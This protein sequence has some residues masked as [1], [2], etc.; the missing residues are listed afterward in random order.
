VAITPAQEAIALL[1][2]LA[3]RGEINPW[4]VQ[5]IEIIDRFLS[6]LGL[7]EDHQ[8]LD[9]KTNL[10]QSGQAFVWASM[11][12][13]LK[14]KTLENLEVQAEEIEEIEPEIDDHSQRALP[15][16]LE[17]HIRRRPAA[18]PPR[19]RRVTLQELIEQIEQ[20]AAELGEKPIKPRKVKP[21]G[22]SRR[23]T[24]RL[25]AELAHNENLTEIAGHLERFFHVGL[26]LLN[27]QQSEIELDQLLDWWSEMT[28]FPES[29]HS[30]HKDCN[31]AKKH[32]R[33]GVF[34]ALLLLSSQSKVE[35]CQKEFYR[36]LTIKPIRST[37]V[38]NG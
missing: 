2:D 11:L 5:V 32:D 21:S 1:T 29:N 20:L 7:G 26:P 16:R 34:W 30:D 36:D 38:F 23:E 17:N 15:L 31:E 33:V 22:G 10:P 28:P 3:Q 25:I 18:P 12:V 14:A 9:P 27:Y 6:E 35:L 8:V 13:L 4:D 24:T 19:K 37:D